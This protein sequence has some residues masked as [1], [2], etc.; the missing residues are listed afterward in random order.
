MVTTIMLVF[1]ILIAVFVIIS[2]IGIN[3]QLQNKLDTQKDSFYNEKL[4]LIA[5]LSQ[6]GIVEIQNNGNV[7]VVEDI[8]F[9][10]N[11]N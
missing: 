5:K 1:T 10:I 3:T 2:L 8:E 6:F 4:R 9:K 7:E 11:N